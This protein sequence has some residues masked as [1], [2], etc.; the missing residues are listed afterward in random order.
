M[1][2]CICIYIYVALCCVGRGHCDELITRPKES[3]SSVKTPAIQV[4]ASPHNVTALRTIVDWF[5]ILIMVVRWWHLRR[6][7][8]K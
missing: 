5:R 8:N 3:R 4:P 6:F 1:D 7:F 2:V